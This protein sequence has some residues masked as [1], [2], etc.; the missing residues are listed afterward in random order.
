MPPKKLPQ[1][2]N[3]VTPKRKKRKYDQKGITKAKGKGL[4]QEKVIESLK[5][6]LQLGYSVKKSCLFAGVAYTTVHTWMRD[7]PSIRIL[8]YSYY[9]YASLTAR[10]NIVKSIAKGSV[11]DSWHWVK[12]KE[13]DLNAPIVTKQDDDFGSEDLENE[14]EVEKAT[15]DLEKLLKENDLI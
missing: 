5:P 7:N 9:N 11:Q 1:P 8:L 6:Y 13:P 14:Q 12:A 10:Q 2:R 4:D 3:S 15:E